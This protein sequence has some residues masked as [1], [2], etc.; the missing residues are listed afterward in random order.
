MLDLIGIY[1][2]VIVILDFWLE[3]GLLKPLHDLQQLRTWF[4][5]PF[6]APFFVEGDEVGRYYSFR[7]LN[8][9]KCINI[10]LKVT[11]QKMVKDNVH[12]VI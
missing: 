10:F 11:N 12:K 2:L 6:H 5:F 9:L 3:T 7:F 4:I 8:I 1:T